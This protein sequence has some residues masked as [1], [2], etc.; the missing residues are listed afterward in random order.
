MEVLTVPENVNKTLDQ[1]RIHERMDLYVEDIRVKHPLAEEN[2]QISG[3]E[4][5]KWEIVCFVWSVGI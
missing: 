3:G 4:K 1:L 2:K 5:C